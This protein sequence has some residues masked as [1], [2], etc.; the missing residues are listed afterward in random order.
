MLRRCKGLKVFCADSIFLSTCLLE[1]KETEVWLKHQVTY[2]R[3]EFWSCILLPRDFFL[4]SPRKHLTYTHTHI[5]SFIHKKNKSLAGRSKKPLINEKLYFAQTRLIQGESFCKHS[6]VSTWLGMEEMA[7][8][9]F[10]ACSSIQDAHGPEASASSYLSK[11][12]FFE[13]SSFTWLLSLPSCSE[14]S[15]QG[16]I[17]ALYGYVQLE[18]NS[19]S[20]GPSPLHH[21]NWST[22]RELSLVDFR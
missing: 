8:S 12:L 2:L 15:T 7:R 21:A 6:V 19:G 13:F 20:S 18:L 14:Q 22:V 4:N 9:G 10:R 16:R 1:S 17:Q 11:S 3:E 5:L